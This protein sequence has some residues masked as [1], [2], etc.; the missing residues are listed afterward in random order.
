MNTEM[1]S[2]QKNKT[3]LLI[4]T[5]IVSITIIAGVSFGFYW[6]KMRN[7]N[8]S[9]DN[10]KTATYSAELPKYKGE[11]KF[12]LQKGQLSDFD[13]AFLK[14]ENTE[15]NKVYSPLSIK[16]ALAMLEEGANGTSK[17]QISNVLGDYVITKYS[18]NQNMS[19]A[20]GLFIRN[21]FRNNVKKEYI[22][23]LNKKYNAD[24]LF[25]PFADVRN[26][27]NWVKDKTLGLIPSLLDHVDNDFLLVNAL[28]ID[29]EWKNK[30]LFPDYEKGFSR[31]V[32]YQHVNYSA[33]AETDTVVF[34]KFDHGKTEISGM[35]IFASIDNYDLVN[36]LGED[37][38]RKT[39]EKEYRA[40]IKENGTDCW[41]EKLTDASAIDKEV[42]RYLEEYMVEIKENYTKKRK[43]S[44]TDFSFYT[45]KNVKAFAKD[46]KTYNGTTLQYIG[47][48][49]TND[50]L[51]DYIRDIDSKSV[52]KIIKNL[53]ELKNENFK[54]D[55]I[56]K[57]TG[58][59]PKFKFEYTLKLKEDLARIGITNIF[60]SEKADM[61][62]LTD[63]KGVYISDAIHK[64]NI[65]FTQDGIKAAAA[66]VVGG[67]GA[68]GPEFD[69]I[70]EVPVEEID[71]T[72]D[73][74]YMF[75][76]R[77]KDTGDVWF[78]GTVY[79]P[80]ESASDTTVE[81]YSAY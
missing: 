54:K 62:R 41:G 29:M 49:P 59:I 21:T 38:I 72:F 79:E 7:R 26:V 25:D 19:L 45:D 77:D 67:V 78:S 17:D 2:P 4:V 6:I 33:W 70:F 66:T 65:E 60:D 20:N 42:S 58:Y 34:R 16:Y 56:T 28:G 50:D 12:D 73:K 31:G 43:A 37:N 57:I 76:V 24:V 10:A 47:I 75:I 39:V 27:N 32:S 52:N 9:S 3:G 64:A 44:N 1:N 55:V 35:E 40:W 13:I 74:P 61:S 81:S 5:V 80:L 48:M 23:Q 11:F 69:Y 15:I 51:S 14:A 68:G 30:F 53:K 22:S 36:T 71:L 18:S 8:T 63:A 46:L